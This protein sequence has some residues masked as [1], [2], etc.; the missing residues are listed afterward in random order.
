MTVVITEE[1]LIS[2]L[3]S[4]ITRVE[5]GTPEA[6]WFEKE[7]QIK[8]S[9]Y[10][11][12]ILFLGDSTVNRAIDEN[13]FSKES[14]FFTLN[15]GTTGDFITYGDYAMLKKYIKFKKTPPKAIIVWHTFDVW[16][17]KMNYNNFSITSPEIKDTLYELKIESSKV[18]TLQDKIMFPVNYLKL[19]ILPLFTYLPSYKYKIWIKKIFSEKLPLDTKK[20]IN[21]ILPEKKEKRQIEK[22][23]KRF[24]EWQFYISNE[25][26]IWFKKMINLAE[27]Y[28]IK[29]YVAR[30]PVNKAFINNPGT[31]QMLDES[32]KILDEFF[33]N[34]NSVIILNNTNPVFTDEFGSIDKDHVNEKGEKL[35][36]IYYSNAMKK[37]LK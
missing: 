22:Q 37:L 23:V 3:S 24:S 7:N 10:K 27:Q 16:S 36:T 29:V 32:N 33:K 19:F 11:T 31:K 35:L 9:T 17:K 34:F 8:N 1:I 21:E 6:I 12:D 13:L 20:I 5:T 30:S 2:V 28:N 26:K 25:S 15:L 18:Y 4:G 14:G